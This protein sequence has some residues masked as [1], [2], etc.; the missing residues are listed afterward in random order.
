MTTSLEG[1]TVRSYAHKFPSIQGHRG[2][3]YVE[4]EN[5]MPSFVAAVEMG[6]D[7]IEL[8]VFRT[9]DDEVNYYCICRCTDR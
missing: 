2:A 4:P 8:D 7:A 5:T 1:D 3:F 9:V 6:A